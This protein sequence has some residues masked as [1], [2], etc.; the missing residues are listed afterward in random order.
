MSASTIEQEIKSL[1]EC[2]W[3]DM[4]IEVGP[5]G[6]DA[7]FGDG[8]RDNNGYAVCVRDNGVPVDKVQ[9]GTL[10]RL[11]EAIELKLNRG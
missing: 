3:P 6:S 10:E 1:A 4:S 5:N 2:I 9:A 7:E 8:A 11:L